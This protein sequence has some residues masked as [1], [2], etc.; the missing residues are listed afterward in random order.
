[1]KYTDTVIIGGG[2]AGLAM[3]CC[4]QEHGVEHVVLERGRVGERWRSERWDSARLLTPNW[5]SRLPHWHYSGK[6]PDGY[7]TM[8]ET[9][10]YLERYAQSFDAPIRTGTTEQAVE[11]VD[12][13]RYRVT[14]DHG[15]WVPETDPPVFLEFLEA[16]YNAFLAG[17]LR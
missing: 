13:G 2:Q 17:R 7:M 5:Q 1:M 10:D 9:I 3:S 15:I 14:T 8:P 4:L 11:R 12:G 16:K 6:D